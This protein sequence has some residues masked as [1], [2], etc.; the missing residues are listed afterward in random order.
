MIARAE[1]LTPEER[2]RAPVFL[3]YLAGERTP[4]NNARAQGVLFGLAHEHGAGAIAHAVV[5]GVSLGLLDGFLAL[6]AQ[7]R[8]RVDELDLVGGGS[9]ST[10]WAHLLATVLERSLVLR[11]GASSSAALG[12]ARLAWLADGGSESD[13]CKVAPVQSRFDPDPLLAPQL[14]ERKARYSA[15][16]AAAT[17]FWS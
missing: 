13:V 14:R 3:P 16:R 7:L 17:P 10:Y 8:T 5:E 2:A 1:A 6:D 12:A 11:E 15:L 9:R 4:L